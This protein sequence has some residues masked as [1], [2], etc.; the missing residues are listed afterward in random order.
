MTVI[1]LITRLREFPP[2]RQVYIDTGYTNCA[3]VKTGTI[4]T[5]YIPENGNINYPNEYSIMPEIYNIPVTI[6]SL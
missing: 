1:Q 6:I 2:D 4:Y 3:A 5:G